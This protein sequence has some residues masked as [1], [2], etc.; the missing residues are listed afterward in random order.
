MD[1]DNH[2]VVPNR[3]A[4][5]TFMPIMVEAFHDGLHEIASLSRW[6]LA[7]LVV[8]NGAATI[9]VLPLQMTGGIKLTAAGAFVFG[10][11]AA[12]GAGLWSC[13]SSTS[14]HRG[15]YDDGLLV[16]DC[17]GRPTRGGARGN[18]ETTYGSGHQLAGD[19]LFCLR[20][21]GGVSRGLRLRGLGTVV[22]GMTPSA[23]GARECPLSTHCCR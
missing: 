22:A 6:L 23:I 9:A 4:A 5:E 7:T 1:E 12:V 10:I 3:L 13:T 15:E 18:P 8:I 20:E 17:G 11:L 2:E 14:E 19:P 21:R 16:G